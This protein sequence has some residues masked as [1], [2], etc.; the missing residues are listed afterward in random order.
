LINGLLLVIYV[1]QTN[2]PMSGLLI[3]WYTTRYKI[4]ICWT[5][6]V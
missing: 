5:S 6:I 3:D 1:L 2:D 4:I